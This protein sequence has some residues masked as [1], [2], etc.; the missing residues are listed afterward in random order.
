M[1]VC[2]Y[3]YIYI[4]MRTVFFYVMVRRPMFGALV[5]KLGLSREQVDVT[6][7]V[8]D[9]PPELVSSLGLGKMIRVRYI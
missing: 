6:M 9:W 4:C 1:Y 7:T 2:M 5:G 8:A 3:I